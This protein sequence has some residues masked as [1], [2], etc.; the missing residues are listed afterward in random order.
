MKYKLQIQTA[1]CYA[2]MGQICTTINRPNEAITYF[3]NAIILFKKQHILDKRLIKCYKNRRE[4]YIK[5][6]EI[7]KA[8]MDLKSMVQI[9]IQRN[10]KKNDSRN[11]TT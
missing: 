5:I 7:E 9:K 1:E 3:T 8:D 11:D 4:A 2:K 10:L 6:G